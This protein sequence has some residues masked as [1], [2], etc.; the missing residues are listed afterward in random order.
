MSNDCY[1]LNGCVVGLRIDVE[2]FT[3]WFVVLSRLFLASVF[4]AVIGLEREIRSKPAGLRTH[5]MVSLGAALF[6]LVPLQFGTGEEVTDALSRVIQ[7]VSTGI[8]FLGAGEIVRQSYRE[9]TGQIRIRGLTS[10]AA[11][12]V[13]AAIG[14][15]V[16]CGL[17]EIALIGTVLSL[18]ILSLLK[19]F[20]N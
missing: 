4:G 9:D 7:G 6:V 8:G 14:V 17:W 20:E 19:R 11:I 5:M 12:W 16:G 18:M 1:K 2:S 3:D 10:A 15:V 13:S